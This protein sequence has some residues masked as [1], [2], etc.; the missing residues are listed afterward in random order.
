MQCR[1]HLTAKEDQGGTREGRT[2]YSRVRTSLEI[3]QKVRVHQYWFTVGSKWS[4]AIWRKKSR[5]VF[6]SSLK[7]AKK[8]RGMAGIATRFARR[9]GNTSALY[10]SV[11]INSCVNATPVF[12]VSVA[13]RSLSVSPLS[14]DQ[15]K[16]FLPLAFATPVKLHCI[17]ISHSVPMAT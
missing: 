14:Q 12:P 9:R 11:F 6:T 7:T 10:L 17:V 8:C 4:Y 3:L 16:V 13:R 1:D 2:E 15:E 5:D